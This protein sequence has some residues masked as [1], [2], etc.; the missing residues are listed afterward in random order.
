MDDSVFPD[1]TY[2]HTVL[3]PLFEG[4]KA[5]HIDGFRQIDRAHLVMLA[6]T[7]ILDGQQAA[8]IA[9]ALSAI[10]AEVDV[11]KLTYTG[12]VEDFFFL[13]ERELKLRLGPDWAGACTPRGR[14]TTSTTRCS[15]WR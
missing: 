6:A 7:G 11:A 8:A 10:D 1:P 2:K 12:E 15:S 4:V 5:D 14:A 9:R 3:G 13:V